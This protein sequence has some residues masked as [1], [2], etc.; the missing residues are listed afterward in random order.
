MSAPMTATG[1]RARTHLP[2]PTYDQLFE[3]RP[4]PIHGAIVVM[5][6]GSLGYDADYWEPVPP[7]PLPADTPEDFAAAALEHARRARAS[8][9][10]AIGLVPAVRSWRAAFETAINPAEHDRLRRGLD[11]QR[12]YVR[13]ALAQVRHHRDRK[14]AALALI[15]DRERAE[16]G[17]VGEATE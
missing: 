17:Q 15:A 16:A 7:D 8:W 13:A 12:G 6:P 10:A 3:A 2:S 4:H 14:R 11:V 5:R 1:I 9:R